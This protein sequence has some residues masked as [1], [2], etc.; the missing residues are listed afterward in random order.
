EGPMAYE[1]AVVL[2]P[3]FFGFGRLGTFYYFADRVAGCLRGAAEAAFGRSTPAMA[4]ATVPAGS[5]AERQ[6]HLMSR[7]TEADNVLRRPARFHLVGHSAG[8][9]DC[10]L[11]RAELPIS[12]R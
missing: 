1:N 5:L 4:L 7:L 9:V 3:G 8:G 11:L 10:E 6:E 2:V 12:A